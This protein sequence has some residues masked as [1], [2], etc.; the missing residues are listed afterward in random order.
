[1]FSILI[2]GYLNVSSPQCLERAMKF[3]FEEFHLWFQLALSLMAAGKVSVPF[4]TVYPILY[5]SNGKPG[6]IREFLSCNF[7]QI[8][9]NN[10]KVCL[11]NLSYIHVIIYIYVFILYKISCMFNTYLYSLFYIL[12]SIKCLK[13]LKMV[14]YAHDATFLCSSKN[15]YC[16]LLLV[17]LKNN[18]FV[19]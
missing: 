16:K 2:W 14:S 10:V 15:K 18:W 7:S 1:M 13:I 17:Q 3:A 19:L 4:S 5:Y 9:I 8:K 6:N 12:G 11:C